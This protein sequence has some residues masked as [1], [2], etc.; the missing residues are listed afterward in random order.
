MR[1]FARRN[2]PHFDFRLRNNIR[3]TEAAF[4]ASGF[5]SRYFQPLQER[6]GGSFHA[7]PRPV[8]PETVTGGSVRASTRRSLGPL[9]RDGPGPFRCRCGPLGLCRGGPEATDPGPPAVFTTIY[10]LRL[11]MHWRCAS[12]LRWTEFHFRTSRS[13]LL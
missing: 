5:R 8:R 9:G 1:L 7:V 6:Q 13:P 2:Q 4:N 12:A 3:L 10:I 11:R